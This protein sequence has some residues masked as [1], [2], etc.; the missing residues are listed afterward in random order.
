MAATS[1]GRGDSSSSTAGVSVG[2]GQEAVFLGAW[3]FVLLTLLA[4]VLLWVLPKRLLRAAQ[5]RARRRR[6]AD[7]RRE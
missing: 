3:D 7:D 4:V 1:R 6:A 2:G 5:A